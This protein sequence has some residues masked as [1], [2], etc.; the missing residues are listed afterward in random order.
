MFVF[1]GSI[2]NLGKYGEQDGVNLNISFKGT[3]SN[4]FRVPFFDGN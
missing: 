2:D 4:K 3:V 1:I